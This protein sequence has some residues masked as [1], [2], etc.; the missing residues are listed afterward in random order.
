MTAPVIELFEPRDAEL[1][2]DAA[3]ESPVIVEIRFAGTAH[4]PERIVF[5][6]YAML[7]DYLARVAR[8]GDTIT[9]WRYKDACRSDNVLVRT[10]NS[11]TRSPG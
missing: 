9:V 5:N 4:P 3:R 10:K 2:R 6:H 7:T 1:L 8:P 11:N